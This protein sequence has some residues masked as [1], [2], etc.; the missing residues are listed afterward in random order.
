MARHSPSG[1]FWE[2]AEFMVPSITANCPGS[3]AARD[4]HTTT[5]IF[6]CWCDVLFLKCCV[7]FTPDVTGSTPSKKFNFVSSVHRIFPQ[8]SWGSSRC[9][10]AKS[11]TRLYV[12]F[13]M[14]A[15]FS[16][17]LSYG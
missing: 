10:F 2:R 3:K 5:T 12:L 1:F 11:E 13:A 8:K 15:I 16:Q 7:T 9:F 6:D 17:S 4:H 14:D